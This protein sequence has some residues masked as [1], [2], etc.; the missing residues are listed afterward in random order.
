MRAVLGIVLAIALPVAATPRP[1]VAPADGTPD[2]S[3]LAAALVA[4]GSHPWLPHSSLRDVASGLALLYPPGAVSLFW[5]D[6]AKPLPALAATAAA[7]GRADALGLD[8]ERFAARR[9]AGEAARA[10]AET[11]PPR[12]RALL[13]VA[14]TVE[15][16][17]LLRTAHAGQIP[18]GRAGRSSFLPA[19]PL[20]LAGLVRETRD[21]SGPDAVLASVEPR[22]PGYARLKA[23]LPRLRALAAGPPLPAL[24]PARKVEPGGSWEG[25]PAVRARLV[26]LGDLPPSAATPPD[27]RILDPDLAAAIRRFQDRHGVRVDGVLGGRTLAELAVPPERRVRQVELAMERWRWL[28]DPG[29]RVVVIEVPRAWLW[30]IDIARGVTDLGMR[31]VVGA[32]DGHETPMFASSITTVVFRPYWIPPPRILRYEILPKARVKPEWLA[33]HG[34]EIVA[35]PAD[36]ATPVPPTEDVLARVEK[37][38]LLLRQR[39]GA[40]NDLGAVKFVIPDSPCIALHGT[41]H[42]ELFQDPDRERSHGCIRLQEPDAFAAWVLSGE[43]VWTAERIA[44]AEARPLPTTVRLREPVPV[45]F[46]YGTAAVDPDGT[47]R[48]THDAYRLDARAE[49]AIAGGAPQGRGAARPR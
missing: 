14:V 10:E 5:F 41:S 15:W 20:D 19:R 43:P 40:R 7:L 34:M 45:V 49:E 32:P 31:T 37:G 46:V 9:I 36:D 16:M 22:Y 42:P 28:P 23:T 25:I 30:A 13:D 38:E 27:A 44:E 17:R 21:G 26:A 4:S 35:S 24:P 1:A 11:L 12:D 48:F 2:A 6:G 29:R 33:A 47:I 18:R 3:A 39:P 8:P